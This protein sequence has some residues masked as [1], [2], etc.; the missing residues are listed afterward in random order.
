MPKPKPEMAKPSWNKRQYKTAADALRKLGYDIS[1]KA[2]DRKTFNQRG[3]IRR[4]YDDK[5]SLINFT[6]PPKRKAAHKAG[7]IEYNYKFQRFS[8]KNL[9]RLKKSGVFTS[10]QFTPNGIFIEKPVNVPASEYKISL[11][12]KGEVRFKGRDRNDVIVPLETRAIVKDANKEIDRVLNSREEPDTYS[13]ICGKY[14]SGL[15]FTKKTLSQY[16]KD[17]LMREWLEEGG[18]YYREGNTKQGFTDVF[19]IRFLYRPKKK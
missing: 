5:K 8:P 17:D 18:K 3:V 11:T 6:E 4:L 2:N 13:L 7:G 9:K 16:L 14:S 19:K 1:Y 12:A 10:E 15:G